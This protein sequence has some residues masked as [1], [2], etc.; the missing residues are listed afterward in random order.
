MQSGYEIAFGVFSALGG[1]MFFLAIPATH[2][3][4]RWVYAD[5]KLWQP[6]EG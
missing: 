2:L 1:T 4:G 3:V 5:Y 6:L